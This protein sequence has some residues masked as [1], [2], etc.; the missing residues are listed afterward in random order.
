M[1]TLVT[2]ASS[3][4]SAA[5][6]HTYSYIVNNSFPRIL[7]VNTALATDPM[8]HVMKHRSRSRTVTILVPPRPD[9]NRPTVVRRFPPEQ[10]HGN[11]DS[12]A[13]WLLEATY[14]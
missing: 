8:R 2:I 3:Q 1:G 4:T 10:Q 14:N 7:H 11:H 6:S 5:I 9:K 12:A 13:S